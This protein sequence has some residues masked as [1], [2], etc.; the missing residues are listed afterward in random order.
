[1]VPARCECYIA[2]G[3]RHTSTNG[4]LR[5]SNSNS[6]QKNPARSGHC[7]Q[8]SYGHDRQ[9]HIPQREGHLC[10]QKTLHEFGCHCKAR[11]EFCCRRTVPLCPFC[12]QSR[13]TLFQRRR[14]GEVGGALTVKATG[15]RVQEMLRHMTERVPNQQA[16]ICP[17]IVCRVVRTHRSIKA[18]VLA[19][20]PMPWIEPLQ[21]R[22]TLHTC[23]P[24]DS[25]QQHARALPSTHATNAPAYIQD[26]L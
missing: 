21:D 18:W 4:V 10:R 26:I 16:P 12:A 13:G 5:L 19:E 23:S 17:D 24:E 6:L 14:W 1:V 2:H 25:G 3:A 15:L 11:V 8:R 7:L 20:D 9:A 22:Q